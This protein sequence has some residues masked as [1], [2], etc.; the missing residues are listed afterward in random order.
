M[1]PGVPVRVTL[2]LGPRPRL[3]L[4]G[5]VVS[6]QP[7]PNLPGQA[8]GIRFSDGLPWGTVAEIA[9]EQ[10]PPCTPSTTPLPTV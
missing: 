8:L 5:T 2:R 4:A 9:D 1:V 10:H 3:T 6:V 7:L